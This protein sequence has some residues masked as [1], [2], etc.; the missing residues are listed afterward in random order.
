ME[1]RTKG[2]RYQ[3]T[4]PSMPKLTQISLSLFAIANLSG[5]GFGMLYGS[6]EGGLVI[7]LGFRVFLRLYHLICSF[8]FTFPGWFG[9]Q[10]S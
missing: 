5:F 9:F 8:E 2:L 10:W 4:S 6:E 1:N 3:L 7:T